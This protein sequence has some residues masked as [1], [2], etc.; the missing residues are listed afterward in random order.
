MKNAMRSPGYSARLELSPGYSAGRLVSTRGQ[1]MPGF[2]GCPHC[3]CDCDT[4]DA[5]CSQVFFCKYND[6]LYVKME[7]LEIMIRLASD[8]NID[9]VMKGTGALG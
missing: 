5:H 4:C 9:Q 2:S 3:G 6:P 1:C 8:K 7:K